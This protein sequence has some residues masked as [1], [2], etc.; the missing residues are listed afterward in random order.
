ME[1]VAIDNS[2]IWTAEEYMQLNENPNQ[3]LIK[4]SLIMSPSPSLNHQQI[5]INLSSILRQYAVKNGDRIYFSPLDIHLDQHN[6]PRPDI[7]YILKSNLNKLSKRGIEGA[8]DLIVE[9]ISPSNSFID[10]YDKKNL[11][12]QFKVQEYWII[13]P[14]NR[15]LE[16]YQLSSEKYNLALYL[17]EEGEVNSPLLK[18]LS[19]KMKEIFELI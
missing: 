16:I 12:E 14:G 15:S 1:L 5:L 4:C 13:D 9:V 18:N 3:Q 17:A 2:K 10:R 7:A 11:Y 8:P 6:V 19:L